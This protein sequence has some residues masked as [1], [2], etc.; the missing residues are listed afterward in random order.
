M[1][2]GLL[3]GW[4][5]PGWGLESQPA[6]L[7]RFLAILQHDPNE[8]AALEP[9]KRSV[10]RSIYRMT[11][12]HA[13][14]Q[15]RCV[16]L[17]VFSVGTI[18]EWIRQRF[19]GPAAIREWMAL[20]ACARAA[21]PA[22]RPVACLM[23]NRGGGAGSSLLV[24]EAMEHAVP[25]SH[26][27][28]TASGETRQA[29]RR[30]LIEAVARSLA[31]S[32]QAGVAVTDL[33]P[34]NLL[35]RTA[36]TSAQCHLVDLGGARHDVK[37]SDRDVVR[38]LSELNQWFA[39]RTTA[40]DRLRFLRQYLLERDLRGRRGVWSRNLGLTLEQLTGRVERQAHRHRELI[41]RQRDKRIFGDNRY[42]ARLR[43]HDGRR[44]VVWLY[45]R[46]HGPAELRVLD[47]DA[48]TWRHAVMAKPELWQASRVRTVL[49]IGGHQL[50]LVQL[51][52]A[53]RRG[54]STRWWLVPAD[55][56]SRQSIYAWIWAW[57][58]LHRH[59]P[60]AGGLWPVL[61]LR[62]PGLQAVAWGVDLQAMRAQAVDQGSRRLLKA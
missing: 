44:A 6:A 51:P 49:E 33:H 13:S 42:F 3:K 46:A 30:V 19:R 58:R 14:G 21:L 60:P 8:W 35:I 57:Y 12:K 55:R 5:V 32:H 40:T 47:L 10:N 56:P 4:V 28:Q 48:D 11:L 41:A 37:V 34:G 9:V 23:H 18:R 26:A 2:A 61:L 62:Q 39:L 15:Q 50:P 52:R 24:S 1:T 16:Y 29:S 59:E 43:L 27:W 54:W 25:L 36:G 38:S 31:A 7:A 22:I 45:W 20:L 53:P 17:K